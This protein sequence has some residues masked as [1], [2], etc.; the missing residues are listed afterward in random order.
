MTTGALS[1]IQKT[2]HYTS[3]GPHTAAASMNGTCDVECDSVYSKDLL[4]ANKAGLVSDK[5]LA[6][7]S[8]RIL[9]HRFL[10]GLFDDPRKT[11]YW[12]GKYNDSSTVHSPVHAAIAREAAQQAVVVVQNNG[13]VLPL[14]PTTKTFALVGPLANVTE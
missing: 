4:N 6:D 8:R 2:H 14:K 11:A 3:D 1:N 10:L 13:A 5:Q 12:G 7:A 9:T